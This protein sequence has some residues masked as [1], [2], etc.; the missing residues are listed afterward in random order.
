MYVR[1]ASDAGFNAF[2]ASCSAQQRAVS[3]SKL[4]SD[5]TRSPHSSS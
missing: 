1:Q 3:R 4:S 2:A 5:A